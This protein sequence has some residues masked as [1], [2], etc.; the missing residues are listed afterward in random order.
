M[1]RALYC[2]VQ[3]WTSQRIGLLVF[4]SFQV[5]IFLVDHLLPANYFT[6]NLS[7][8]QADMVAFRIMLK[9]HLPRL[10]NH[11]RFL[12]EVAI[13]FEFGL[14]GKSSCPTR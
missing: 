12:Q 10:W 8:L 2:H 7:T 6:N 5:M 13:D 14:T 9:K 1:L 4:P 11:L 3:K